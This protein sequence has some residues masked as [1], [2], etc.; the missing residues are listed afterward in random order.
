MN[1]IKR[2]PAV[3]IWLY[4]ISFMVLAM[5]LIGGVTRLTDSGLSMV[6]WKPILGAIP[7]I[8]EAQWLEKFKMY[9]AFPEF[10]KVNSHMDLAGFKSIFFWEYFHR[11][12]GRLIGLFFFVPFAFFALTKSFDKKT[13]F[14]MFLALVLGGSQGLM[15]WYMVKSGLV[16]RPDVSHFR[17]AAHL[18][19][20]FIILAYLFWLVLEI[21]NPLRERLQKIE[22]FKAQAFLTILIIVQIIYGAFVAGLDAGLTHNTFPKMG[23]YW[24]PREFYNIF[25]SIIEVFENPVV[26]QFVHRSI[27]ILIAVFAVYM[28]TKTLKMNNFQQKKTIKFLFFALMMQV[29]LGILTLVNY[30]P[31]T[32][33]SAH[34]VMAAIITLCVVRLWFFS[35]YKTQKSLKA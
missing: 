29:V 14:K 28:M 21:K 11:L 23:R 27:G 5:V 18:G 15:G 6:D 1:H 32:L 25:Q 34:Q 20:A 30:V 16:D 26:I 35:I 31:I 4:I 7:P 22:Y 13:F 19:L 17:L 9:Q 12:F 10:Q 24:I 33:A 8:N 3:V 2:A